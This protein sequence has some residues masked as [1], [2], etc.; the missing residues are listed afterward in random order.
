MTGHGGF[1]RRKAIP[2]LIVTAVVFILPIGAVFIKAFTSPG[3][4]FRTFADP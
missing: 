1:Y 4:P 2:A 3:E